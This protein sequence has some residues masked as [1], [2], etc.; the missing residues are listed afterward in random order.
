MKLLVV[1]VALFSV[2]SMG[3]QAA[4]KKTTEWFTGSDRSARSKLNGKLIHSI[5][6]RDGKSVGL[7]VRKGEYKVTYS[8]NP[9]QVKFRWAI[10]NA[11]GPIAKWAKKNGYKR[12]SFDQYR[13][14]SSGLRIRCGV[15]Q[16]K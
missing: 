11:Y 14:K 2:Y 6:C 3:A 8:D 10:G 9:K 7:N 4:L 16:K 15:W 12:V 1:I 13:R 5:K